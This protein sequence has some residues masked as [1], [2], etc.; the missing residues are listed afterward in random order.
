MKTITVLMFLKL[1]IKFLM[2]RLQ[3]LAIQPNKI[4]SAFD[5]FLIHMTIIETCIKHANMVKKYLL[6]PIY[7]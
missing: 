7:F 5:F 4:N 1:K 6:P 3:W 2:V